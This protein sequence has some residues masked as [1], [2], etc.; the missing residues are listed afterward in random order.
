VSR[1]T[2]KRA[3]GER[4]RRR[5]AEEIGEA[6]SAGLRAA[7]GGPRVIGHG[8]GIGLWRGVCMPPKLFQEP[9]VHRPTALC[10]NPKCFLHLPNN[11]A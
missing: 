8:F 10:G 11:I 5:A 3:A 6:R 9:R 2:A 7:R 4:A 1:G